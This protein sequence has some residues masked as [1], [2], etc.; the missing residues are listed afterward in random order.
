MTRRIRFD[1]VPEY[2]DDP[3]P[4]IL[5]GSMTPLAEDTREP[6]GLLDENGEL[7]EEP[8]HPIGFGR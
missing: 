5:S 4:E 3:P 1:D 2:E 7:I 8:E 6:E